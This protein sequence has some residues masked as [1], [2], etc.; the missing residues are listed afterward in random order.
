[1][2]G[3]KIGSAIQDHPSRPLYLEGGVLWQQAVRALRKEINKERDGGSGHGLVQDA[4]TQDRQQLS[5]AGQ[6]LLRICHVNCNAFA[7]LGGNSVLLKWRPE[8][9]DLHLIQQPRSTRHALPSQEL[10][11]SC[12][13]SF[14][15]HAAMLG[16]EK[17]SRACTFQGMHQ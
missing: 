15:A 9:Q 13:R 8:Q 7:A 1:M 10:H 3:V 12:Q 16:P 14:P 2:I 17:C 5:F 4:F 11:H 6:R